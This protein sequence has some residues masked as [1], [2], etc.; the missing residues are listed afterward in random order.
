MELFRVLRKLRIDAGMSQRDFAIAS[1]LRQERISTIETDKECVR[2][3]TDELAAW[4]QAAG[5]SASDILKLQEAMDKWQTCPN[6][7]EGAI[8]PAFPRKAAMFIPCPIC[9]GSGR[10][11]PEI[12]Y[13]LARGQAMREEAREKELTLVKNSLRLG[14]STTDMAMMYRGFFRKE[15]KK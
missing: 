15:A 14:K 12:E 1:G 9:S 6:C 4:G 5:F 13:N 7:E 2:F 8:L 3:S 11:S 10:L